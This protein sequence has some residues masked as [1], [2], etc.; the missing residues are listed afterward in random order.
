MSLPKPETTIPQ[1]PSGLL[2]PTDS[3]IA[4]NALG[5]S[6]KV[7]GQ[8][9]I[10][11]LKGAPGATGPVAG[12]GRYSYS[13]GSPESSPSFGQ[14]RFNNS[15]LSQ[16]T[17]MYINSLDSAPMDNSGWLL[18]MGDQGNILYL[19]NINNPLDYAAFKVLGVF[20]NSGV[21]TVPVEFYSSSDASPVTLSASA[22]YTLNLSR[23]GANGTHGVTPNALNFSFDTLTTEGAGSGNFRLNAGLGG[24]TKLYLNETSYASD[25]IGSA[26]NASSFLNEMLPNG[27]I[28]YIQNAANSAIFGIYKYT[29]VYT[30]GGSYRSVDITHVASNGTFAAFAKFKFV[31]NPNNIKAKSI[32]TYAAMLASPEG[33]YK[34]VTDEHSGGSNVVYYW[35]GAE[36]KEVGGGGVSPGDVQDAVDDAVPDAIN[37]LLIQNGVYA[38]EAAGRAAVADGVAFK[39]QGAGD[40]AAYEYRRTNGSTSV[41]IATYP[42]AESVA[43]ITPTA[44]LTPPTLISI[45]N[46]PALTPSTQSFNL[47]RIFARTDAKVPFPGYV[48]KFQ[49]ILKNAEVGRRVKYYV[50]RETVSGTYQAIYVSP[51]IPSEIDGIQTYT[52][53]VLSVKVQT[54]DVIGARCIYTTSGNSIGFFD[55][56]GPQLYTGID[57]TSDIV[58]GATAVSNVQTA[59]RKHTASATIINENLLVSSQWANKAG[60]Y[61]QIDSEKKIPNYIGRKP[62]LYWQGKKIIW[63]GTSIPAGTNTEYPA[64]PVLAGQYLDAIMDNQSVGS[65]GIIWDGT[66]NLSLS[67]TQAELTSAFGA[68]FAAQS[69]EAK[70]IGKGAN[71]I[72]FDHGGNDR[73]AA[74]GSALGTLAFST[75]TGSI[76]TST[77]SATVTGSG[78]NFTA[79]FA[80]GDKLYTIGYRYIGT[81]LSIQSNTSLTLSANAL[82]AGASQLYRGTSMDRTKFY[83]AFNYVFDKCYIENPLVS[84]AIVLPPNRYWA[85]GSDYAALDNV[86]TAL[87]ALAQSWSLPYLDMMSVLQ[88]N[89]YNFSIRATDGIHPEGFERSAIAQVIYHWIK[90]IR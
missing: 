66:R 70:I 55:T 63:V 43:K 25:D 76:T 13:T 47:S 45:V 54:N 77:S 50:L 62:D 85:Y 24:A 18:N 57:F 19:Y 37:A 1:L 82:I 16:A 61:V 67:A 12:V 11:G 53:P 46:D 65:S 72:I 2:E 68:G 8:S 17:L 83:G 36:A 78:S 90:G 33:L 34:V 80:V 75:R 14:F 3:F 9:I 84:I 22:V 81:V 7:T 29:G 20:I 30:D 64:Y 32:A 51:E 42:S 73:S 69:Y 58:Q 56:G 59:S 4:T 49:V 48:E 52:P 60:G 27:G 40:V 15:D 74:T 38:T 89:P 23:V 87:I 6:K 71:L 39:V 44:Y 5:L 41:L 28:L 26:F 86:R 31:F 10:D 88:Y 35:N 21:G 79:E